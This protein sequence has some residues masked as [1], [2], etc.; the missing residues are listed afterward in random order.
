MSTARSS[1]SVSESSQF[2]AEV[3]I[4]AVSEKTL[5]MLAH[6]LFIVMIGLLV[7][8]LAAAHPL[9]TFSTL[10]VSEEDGLVRNIKYA[11]QLHSSEEVATKTSNNLCATISLANTPPKILEKAFKIFAKVLVRD[12]RNVSKTKLREVKAMYTDKETSI[13]YFFIMMRAFRKVNTTWEGEPIYNALGEIAANTSNSNAI[14]S[15]TAWLDKIIE[16]VVCSLLRAQEHRVT[17]NLIDQ[18]TFKKEISEHFDVFK[19][20]WLDY[21]KSKR[22]QYQSY[23]TSAP[24]RQK[25]QANQEISCVIPQHEFA[26]KSAHTASR[27]FA[28]ILVRDS[29]IVVESKLKASDPMNKVEI[30]DL[31]AMLR[32]IESYEIFDGSMQGRLMYQKLQRINQE[33]DEENSSWHINIMDKIFCLAQKVHSES[34][35]KLLVGNTTMTATIKEHFDIFKQFWLN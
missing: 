33:R 11:D 1:V 25:K 27:A 34:D 17:D 28:E 24:I 35:F 13:G 14:E 5:E 32:N 12:S 29:E 26:L 15:K 6:R 3:K 20:F 19:Q 10:F 30:S 21:A 7:T 2:T 4:H 16:G 18:I 23:T 9:L 22:A 31:S 8:E